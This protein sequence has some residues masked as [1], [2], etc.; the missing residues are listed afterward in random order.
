MKYK[1]TTLFLLLFLCF[2]LLS[3]GCEKQDYEKQITVFQS[4][5]SDGSLTEYKVSYAIILWIVLLVLL[6]GGGGYHYHSGKKQ[7]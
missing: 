3:T 2:T 6:G 4:S 7:E 1:Y 5:N